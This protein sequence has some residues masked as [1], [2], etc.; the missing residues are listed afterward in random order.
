M[1][2]NTSDRYGKMVY[3]RCGRSGLKLPAISLGA[4]ETFG[5]YRGE[6]TARECLHGAFD[7][8]ITH[9]DLAN[10]YGNPPGN[11]EIVCGK[12]IRTMPRD[13][14]IVSSKAGCPMWAGPYGDWGSRKHL[15]A[16]CDQ[17]LKRSGLE[18]FDIFYSHRHDAETPI[19]ETMGALQQIV[20]QGKALYVGVS[21]YDGAQYMQARQAARDIG[22]PI[23]I[24][25]QHYNML[26]RKAEWDLFPQAAPAGT[27]VIVYCPLASGLLTN[28]YLGGGMPAHSRAAEKWGKGWLDDVL[29][30]QRH[31]QLTKLSVIA[32]GR[33]Q[34]LAQMTL[35]WTLHHPAI[36]SALVG[37]SSLKQVQENVKALERLEFSQHE[38]DAIDKIA[39]AK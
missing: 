8:G 25:Q 19:E 36:T 31:E 28:K 5:G 18:Y 13:E 15:L 11:A 26:S 7:L 30:P 37:A 29:T 27:G 3:R 22:L 10:N 4:W 17:S 16:S 14:L 34:S 33:G 38:L 6:D 1:S 20:R 12:V 2:N 35:A 21:N 39:P 23:T 24:H 32:E 9:F